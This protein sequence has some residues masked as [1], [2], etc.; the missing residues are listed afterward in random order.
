MYLEINKMNDP[1][2]KKARCAVIGYGSWATALIKIL[3]ENETEVVWHIRNSEVA[4]HIRDHHN[5]PKYISYTSLDT[6]KLYITGDI[7]DAFSR[8]DIIILAVPSA[9]LELTLEGLT[10][11]IEDKIIFSAIKGIMPNGFL[12]IAEYVNQRFNIPF[13]RLG[14]LTGPC[15]A[16]EVAL[17][18][19]TYI[20]VVTTDQEI[21]EVMASKLRCDYIKANII[22]DI[23]GTEYSAVMKNIYAI[24]VGMATGGGYG[25]NFIAVLIA[26]AAKEISQFLDL[27][28]RD[29][30]E[31]NSSAYIGDLLVTCYSKFSR[32]RAFG[33]MIGKGYSVKTAQREMDM[34]AEGYWAAHCIH[35]ICRLKG[36]D[37]P[38]AESVYRI[39]YKK[40][41]VGS[42]FKKLSNKLI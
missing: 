38:I 31:L 37:L 26:N 28:Y 15:H 16:E 23:Y 20:N 14:V 13:K 29:E 11:P 1:L 39:L 36:I 6:S 40:N 9:F 41:S 27:T 25:D 10:L 5:N 33:L 3:L 18:R 17:E 42:E 24:A 21:G 4:D 32:N 7:N 22:T 19:L 8:A 12:T 2:D 30:R 35:K 34:V